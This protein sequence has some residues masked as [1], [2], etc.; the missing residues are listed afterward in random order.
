MCLTSGAAAAAGGGG[1]GMPGTEH[2]TW[3]VYAARR[4]TGEGAV[5]AWQLGA[6]GHIG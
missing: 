4:T 3:L 2:S 5:A 1:G 6:R